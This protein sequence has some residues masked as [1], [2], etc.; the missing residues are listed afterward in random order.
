MMFDPEYLSWYVSQ[1]IE[2]FCT[3]CAC[4]FCAHHAS[5]N[6][7]GTPY[8][9]ARADGAQP[10]KTTA[11]TFAAPCALRLV[12]A[13][14]AAFL[15]NSNFLPVGRTLMQDESVVSSRTEKA[16]VVEN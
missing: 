6:R 13:P 5:V 4:S 8:E 10:L 9:R 14:R 11:C 16:H 7:Q 3:G 2:A 15:M 12:S 1:C